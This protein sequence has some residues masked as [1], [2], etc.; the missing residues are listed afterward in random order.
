M[1]LNGVTLDRLSDR[2]ALLTSLDNFRRDVDSSGMMEGMD[3]FNRQAMDVLTSS[4][5]VDALDIKKEKAEV[6]ARYKPETKK[7][8]GDGGS[9]SLEPFL[10][11]RRLV[12]AGARCVT[13]AWGGW[14]SHGNNFKSLSTQLPALDVGV[15]A[16]VQDLHDRGLDKDV[17]VVMW[18]EFGRTPNVNKNAGRDHWPRGV[19]RAAGGRRDEERAGDRHDRPPRRRAR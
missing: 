15:S 3:A 12:E 13:L 16:L 9:R 10:V 14:D 7:G 6:L 1:V 17:S 8:G 18:G 11:A 4:K 5:L 2:K 19:V